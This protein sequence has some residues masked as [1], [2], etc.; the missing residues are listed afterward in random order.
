MTSKKP[1]PVEKKF[2]SIAFGNKLTHRPSI[3]GEVK[4]VSLAWQRQRLAEAQAKYHVAWCGP[5]NQSKRDRHERNNPKALIVCSICGYGTNNKVSKVG[6]IIGDS[7]TPNTGAPMSEQPATLGVPVGS[8]EI[9][10]IGFQM[11]IGALV[12]KFGHE[13][14]IRLQQEDMTGIT[15][16]KVKFIQDG[17]DLSI[18]YM[19]DK[20]FIEWQAELMTNQANALRIQAAAMPEDGMHPEAET[21]TVPDA[22]PE[23][24]ALTLVEETAPAHYA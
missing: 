1:A 21:V 24:P 23:A 15:P 9:T 6:D 20:E 3:V 19:T 18:Q 5:D 11:M 7:T 12:R 4:A 14:V 2:G 22:P 16:N 8:P 10:A 17:M 13:N